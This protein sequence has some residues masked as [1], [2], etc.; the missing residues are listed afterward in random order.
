[1]KK[2]IKKSLSLFMAVMMLLSCWVWVA[3][4]KAAAAGPEDGQYYLKYV[5][6]NISEAGNNDKWSG[7]TMT[8][9]YIKADGNPDS[10]TINL[11]KSKYTSTGTNK[12]IWEGYVDGFPT[13]AGWYM[14]MGSKAFNSVYLNVRGAYMLVG[15][16][17]ASC[18]QSITS[19]DKDGGADSFKWQRDAIG[20]GTNSGT[21]TINALAEKYPQI[22]T[23]NNG[24]AATATVTIPKINTAAEDK[25]VFTNNF[26][27]KCY[28]QYGVRIVDGTELTESLEYGIKTIQ[29]DALDLDASFTKDEKGF[30][31]ENGNVW[32][33]KSAQEMM[34]G[35]TDTEYF[36]YAHFNS[37]RYGEKKQLLSTITLKYPTYTVSVNQHGSVPN[38]GASMS[39]NDG[40]AQTDT[41]A[42]TGIYQSVAPAYPTGAAEKEGYSFKGF[43]TKE[44]PTTGGAGYNSYEAD[45]VVPVSSAD[46]VNVYGGKKAD[47]DGYTPYVEKDGKT[48]YDAGIQW[49]PT[50]NREVLEDVS[51]YGWWNAK[52][53][54]AKFYDIDGTY[55]G[56]QTTKY[57]K[58]E[59]E[60]WYPNPKDGYTSGAYEY[61]GFAK[62]WRDITG[63]EIPEGEYTFGPLP[64]LS[65][66]PIYE[67]K[68]Y[69]DKYTVN[70]VDPSIG[71]NIDG[72]NQDNG[73]ASGSYAYRHIL[74][75]A[76][77]PTVSVPALIAYDPGYS[78]EFSGWTSLKPATGNYH[79][80]AKGDETFAE[81]TDW[82]VREDVT[83]YA[84][85]RSTVKEYAVS[86]TYIDTTGTQVTEIKYVP[87][88]S[89]IETPENV[90]RT[91]AQG[92]YGYTLE[93]WDYLQ[94]GTYATVMLGADDTLVFNNENVALSDDNLKGKEPENPVAFT[95][96]YDAGKP[97]PYTVTFK[98]KA[99][100]G[101]DKSITAQVYHGS[102]ITSQT[103]SSLDAVPAQY[104]D[105]TALYTFSNKWIVTEGTA[106]KAEYTKD[107]FTSFA[108]KS[109][110]TF[111]AVYGE[112]VPFYTVTYTDGEKNYSERILAGSTLPAWMV[113][114]GTDENGEPVMKEYTPAKADSETGEY[115]FEGWFDEMQ[116]DESFEAT[117]GTKYTV[118][119][120]VNSDLVL[121]P[122]FKFSPFK[123]QIKFMNFDGTVQLAAAEVEAGQSFADAFYWAQRAAQSRP[124]DETY[125]YTFIGWDQPYNEDNLVCEGKD[126]TFTALYRPAYRYYKAFWYNS[127]AEMTAPLA[128]TSYTYNGVV[129]A[130][131]VD[132]EIPEGK[133][134]DGWYYMDG[135]TEK[136]Y[137]RGMN[138][139]A[140]MS[141]YAK[142]K[143]A[144]VA[145]TITA[146]IDGKSTE[147][148]IAEGGNAEVVGRPLDGY[149]DENNHNK[150]EGW[151][152][153]ADFAAGTE[154]DLSAVV[155]GDK[156]IYAKFT[157]TPH[158]KDQ[159][160]LVTAPTYYTKGSEKVWC[161]CSASTAET[162]EIP[163]LTD[164]VAPTGTIYLGTQ[165]K[166][167][168]TDA[169]F[170]KD[171]TNKYYANADTDLILT[172]NDTAG[173]PDAGTEGHTCVD[174][175]YNPAGTGKGIK[176]IR[177]FVS[178]DTFTAEQAEEASKL[179]V[180]IFTDDT[181]ELNNTANYT[182][183]VNAF[184]GVTL[185]D[186]EEYIIYY[187][188]ID[189]ANNV[190]NTNVRTAKFVYDNTAPAFTVEGESNAE[191]ATIS[192]ITYCGKATV[193]GVEVGAKL[194]VNGEEVALTTTSAAGTGTY[195]ID[196]AGNY[197]ITAT[198]FAGNTFSKKIVVT[199][200]HDEVT[201]EKAATCDED[202]YKKI[203]CAVCGKVIKNETIKSE[204]HKYGAEVVV[205]PTCDEDGYSVKTC[206][207]CGD[208]VVTPG[209][210]AAGHQHAKDAEGNIIYEVVTPATCSTT[211]KKISNCTVCGKDTITVTIPVD[212]VNGHSYGAVKVLKATCD[213]D[214]E[215]YQTCKYCY[216]K[217]TVNVLPK[218]NH[219][220][221][222]R[223]TK[224]TTEATCYSEG[225]ETTYCK[226]CDVAMSTAPVAKIA[227]TLVLVRYDKDTDK[228]DDYPNGYMQY[229]CMVEG[230]GHTEGKTAIAAKAQY[231]VTFKGAGVDGADLVI[232]KTEGETIAATAVADQTKG[233]D[234]E[235]E[236][237]FA[238]WKGSDG[239]VVKLPITVSKN[240]TYTAEF[241]AVK[242][243]YTHTFKVNKDDEAVFATIIGTYGAAD[244]K[245]TREPVKAEDANNTYEFAG[246]TTVAGKKV[247]DYTMKG[248]ATFVAEFTPIAKTYNVNFYVGNDLYKNVKVKGGDTV[249][250]PAVPTKDSDD[251]VHYTFAGWYADEAFENAFSFTTKITG[252][253][254]VYAKFNAADHVYN[255]DAEGN[256][257]YKSE[258][259]AT[260]TKEGEGVKECTVCQ[261]TSTDVL[262]KAAH[263]YETLEDGSQKCKVCGDIIAAEVAKVTV[264]FAEKVGTAVKELKKYEVA[265]GK[266]VEYTALEKADTA[267]YDYEFVN[268]TDAEGNVVSTEAKLTVTAGEEDATY[269]ANYT[270]V[271]R[272]YYVSYLDADY[273][274]IQST[275]VAYGTVLPAFTGED[276][277]KAPTDNDHYEFVGWSV[278]AGTVV[279]GQLDITPKFDPMTHTWGADGET[280]TPPTCIAPGTSNK[281]CTV[282][283]KEVPSAT[284]SKPTGHN[285][286]LVDHKDAGYGVDGYDKYVCQNSWCTEED[287]KYK[288]DVIPALTYNKLTVTVKD[289]DK[290]VYG[291]AVKLYKDGSIVDANA[292]NKDGVV[293]FENLE[294]GNYVVQLDGG[295]SENVAV[296]A[297]AA[298][299]VNLKDEAS[300]GGD[301]GSQSAPCSCSC[302]RNGFWGIL[303]RFFH[304]FISWFT[305]RINCCSNPDPRY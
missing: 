62:K 49:D 22:T 253:T 13:S 244:K 267:Q 64:S 171:D 167:S 272:E 3:P 198:D 116:T 293:V 240:E 154:F 176:M 15:A 258:T 239:K 249:S 43:W 140:D 53:V 237:E 7:N 209:A 21:F 231:S 23:I 125:T 279:K 211:G 204:G 229:E 222:G 289:G 58:K 105:G 127:A 70:F 276:P 10:K 46:F 52:D 252:T 115:K 288:T 173:C 29:N 55:L 111:E 215:E 85:F 145:Y 130:P 212:T 113:Q 41:W 296:N 36:L 6:S 256:I 245:P 33:N 213:A 263:D 304:T 93:G 157:V 248:D 73:I 11:D 57:G 175:T 184:E 195:V 201:T 178:S 202:G 242:R 266:T 302:H 261:H 187:Y 99:A 122:Q 210:T 40:T 241:T 225:V 96:N 78:Y 47:E 38:I 141:F 120:E 227:H 136:A 54:S 152:T 200:G 189:K 305:G 102:K 135:E 149:V 164:T 257:I 37:S 87:Y 101:A 220:D 287:G 228:S 4:E 221:T 208:E 162:A 65:L 156:T 223:Y 28:D 297:D 69:S 286:K 1:M 128:T 82:V 170:A 230:C 270:A 117:N 118:A 142:Y 163:M 192:T 98:Y 147:Y 219:V 26:S 188:A 274:V 90:N 277:V 282:C 238:G 121:Y 71:I 160:E 165:G 268:W 119:S 66:T 86:F 206:S 301:S 114:D 186:G 303:F 214:G 174:C 190:L 9:N 153:S 234:D 197:L 45:F 18:T 271:V 224:I 68:T 123:Y 299:T 233:M 39:M 155:T 107:E 144:P 27:V 278:A 181:Q 104:D 275:K 126:V 218:L 76:N 254:R 131:S 143:D 75:G 34:P 129:Y 100:D 172:I 246:W 247:D 182:V 12:V 193:T 255:T 226:A 16:D 92:G 94:A 59:A 148:E 236:Y 60:G 185:V 32:Y 124:A 203:I 166:W 63:A 250:E 262:A 180:T 264:T 17:A 151:F 83:Y 169:V 191:T 177:A 109:H 283:G 74:S 284:T 146:I 134:F 260:C 259:P 199:D 112:G 161:A 138:I 48:Y 25:K 194:T 61:K 35:K 133:M 294:D 14:E 280:S 139:T 89:A 91:Y 110:I 77:I 243:I 5:V 31:Y 2:K 291:I 20:Q 137:Q 19:R 207:V 183:K 150:F 56:T 300:G 298:V 235:Y 281:K 67:T 95:A 80:F 81:N 51:F 8:I 265:E 84:V 216:E 108:P 251:S 196:E 50:K 290:L 106:D 24:P 30:W 42:Y 79:V 88:G 44:Q 273:N 179:A 168:S 269:T 295:K 232:T 158:K 103:V 159:R 292:T 285:Y 97:T 205:E 132:L 72:N 217:K